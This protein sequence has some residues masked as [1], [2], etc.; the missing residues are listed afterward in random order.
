MIAFRKAIFLMLSFLVVFGGFFSFPQTTEAVKGATCGK[1]I[2][3]NND[4]GFLDEYLETPRHSGREEVSGAWDLDQNVTIP[5]LGTAGEVHRYFMECDTNGDIVRIKYDV[6]ED[7]IEDGDF[8]R[9]VVQDYNIDGSRKGSPYVESTQ[10]ESITGA[11]GEAVTEAFDNLQ[12]KAASIARSVFGY[13][14][15]GLADLLT[16]FNHLIVGVS[17]ALF[18]VSLRETVANLA[19]YI[20]VSTETG[21]QPGLGE[22][23]VDAW[24]LFRNLANL[25]FIFL[26]LFVAIKTILRGNGFGDKRLLGGIVVVALFMNFS[27]LLTQTAINASNAVSISIYNAITYDDEAQERKS[28]ALTFISHLKLTTFSDTDLPSEISELDDEFVKG[29]LQFIMALIAVPLFVISG[30]GLFIA[31]LFLV[32]RLISFI[33]LMITSPVAFVCSIIP[34]TRSVWSKWLN[35]LISNSLSL[36]VMMIGLYLTIILAQGISGS[37]VKAGS[38]FADLY[39]VLGNVWGGGTS[40]GDVQ[41][42][43]AAALGG[44]MLLFINFFVVVAALFFSLWASRKVGI[45]GASWATAAADTKTRTIKYGLRPMQRS[46]QATGRG[47][48][49][50]GRVAGGTVLKAGGSVT[51]L[52][53]R[54]ALGRPGEALANNS[55][56]REMAARRGV[57]GALG[58]GIQGTGNTLASANYGGGNLQ[59]RRDRADAETERLMKLRESLGK[60]SS[61][62]E[63]KVKNEYDQAQAILKND[64]TKLKDAEKNLKDNQAELNKLTQEALKAGVGA[65]HKST[66]ENADRDIKTLEKKERKQGALSAADQTALAVARTSRETAQNAIISAANASS[67]I[68]DAIKINMNATKDQVSDLES[69]VTK[70]KDAKTKAQAEFNT[71]KVAFKDIEKQ[72]KDRVKKFDER[73]SNNTLS[74]SSEIIKKNILTK[75]AAAALATAGVSMVSLPI[76]AGAAAVGGIRYATQAPERSGRQQ[77]TNRVAAGNTKPGGDKKKS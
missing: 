65:T 9:I 44:V 19:D 3:E 61:R 29:A 67:S 75:G 10:D 31:A 42:Q 45:S 11:I 35:H 14:L 51:G 40:T 21:A 68:S 58:R 18:E 55:K 7:A 56:V 46:V 62:K 16:W 64:T 77:Y 52:A 73:V 24:E 5:G 30:I 63:Q 17:G 54:A 34:G 50:A 36:P 33:F 48:Q 27:L 25:I 8:T 32:I 74:I 28:L 15:A 1:W 13:I 70:A 60:F 12:A 66:F 37:V 20:G 4:G 69:A 2:D 43:A 53:G 47:A 38:A 76:S 6:E 72:V 57:L 41:Q 23:I 49:R 39:G 26:I 22:A 71:T 59:A